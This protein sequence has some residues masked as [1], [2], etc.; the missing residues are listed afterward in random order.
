MNWTA[1]AGGTMS[2]STQLETYVR[3]GE[4]DPQSMLARVEEALQRFPLVRI[5][6]HVNFPDAGVCFFSPPDEFLAA[7][8]DRVASTAEPVDPERS[9][10]SEEHTS[11]LQS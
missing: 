11:E 2:R 10:R 5:V 3:Y 9:V 7:P 4:L 6:G 1:R 8:G